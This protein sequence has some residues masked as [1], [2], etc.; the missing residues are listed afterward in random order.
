MRKFQV[1]WIGKKPS[2][3][4]THQ[5]LL[6]P[7]SPM[8]AVDGRISTVKATWCVWLPA[9][10]LVEYTGLLASAAAAGNKFVIEGNLVSVVARDPFTHKD[11]GVVSQDLVVKF[12]GAITKSVEVDNSVQW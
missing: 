11:T 5:V 8:D 3:Y 9:A 1:N 7:L 6:S 10:A 4:D 12:Q 2:Q